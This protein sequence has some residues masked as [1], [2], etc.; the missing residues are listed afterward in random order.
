MKFDVLFKRVR[1]LFFL[2]LFLSTVA[3][4][5]MCVQEEKS[6]PAQVHKR[7]QTPRPPYPYLEE[8]VTYTSKS[9]E[10]TLVGTLT[11]PRSLVPVPA[12]L[13][14]AGY[15]PQDRNENIFEHKIFLVLADHLTRQGIAVL[16]VD[17]RGIG[18]STGDWEMATS[19]DF[20]DDALAGIEYL[21]SRKE[22]HSKKIGV[23][24][25]SEGAMITTLLAAVS[26]DVAFV[27]LLGGGAMNCKELLYEQAVFRLKDSG[28]SK[29]V[30]AWGR[31]VLDEVMD[32]IGKDVDLKK[33]EKKI[34]KFIKKRLTNLSEDQNKMFW[35]MF[36]IVGYRDFEELIKMY[37]TP[38]TR[39]WLALDIVGALKKITAPVLAVTGERDVHAYT[40]QLPVIARILEEGNNTDYTIMKL[41]KL[42]HIFQTCKTGEMDEWENIE[43]TFAPPALQAISSWILFKFA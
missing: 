30:Y 29:N 33:A 11:I 16:R 37:N 10:I 9:S 14:I 13:L 17:K 22:I 18:K 34:R 5:V 31:R 12:V 6:V 1:N 35:A 39:D 43:E 19:Q 8:E 2:V 41:P 42:N 15:G 28:I 36:Q 21:K 32:L 7:P 4:F 27:V 3:G 25:H 20:V 38:G 26:K 40:M 23:I 24:G